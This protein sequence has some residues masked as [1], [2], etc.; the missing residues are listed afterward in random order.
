MRIR[1]SQQNKDYFIYEMFYTNTI[2]TRKHKSRDTEHKKM[3]LRKSLQKTIKPAFQIETQGKKNVQCNQEKK[4]KDKISVLSPH[5]NH[6][7]CKQIAL[8]HQRSG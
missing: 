6:S 1:C 3:K 8:I 4:K 5:N 7:K 2:V